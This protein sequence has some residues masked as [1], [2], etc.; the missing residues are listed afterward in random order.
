VNVFLFSLHQKKQEKQLSKHLAAS[1][2][3]LRARLT[4]FTKDPIG[5]LLN[6]RYMVLKFAFKVFTKKSE[7]NATLKKGGINNYL[8]T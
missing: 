8:A 5:I 7:K 2:L 4:T 3:L 6:N 1:F